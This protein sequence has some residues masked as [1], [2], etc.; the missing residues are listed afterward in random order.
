MAKAPA[1][2]R[3]L[4]RQHTALAINTLAHYAGMG[5]ESESVHVQAAMALLDRG[6]GKAPQSHTG[7]NGEGEIRVLVRHIIGGRD[8]GGPIVEHKQPLPIGRSEEK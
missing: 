6:W 8:V 3:S 1:D 7:E 4:A 5:G 2:I